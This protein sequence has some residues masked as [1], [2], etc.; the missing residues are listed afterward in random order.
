M[1]VLLGGTLLTDEEVLREG[2]REGGR[3]GVSVCPGEDRDGGRE[4]D[5]GR[6]EGREGRRVVCAA[7]STPY[8][9]E[10][11]RPRLAN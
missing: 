4:R 8:L 3:E 10:A 7:G 6:E 1:L 11:D 5:E 9:N 2:G